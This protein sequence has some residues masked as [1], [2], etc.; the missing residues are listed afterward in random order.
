MKTG[1]L[2]LIIFLQS[3][4]ILKGEMKNPNQWESA[5]LQIKKVQVINPF[6]LSFSFHTEVK[7]LQ[8][9]EMNLGNQIFSNFNMPDESTLIFFSNLP[10]SQEIISGNLTLV[11]AD[12]LEPMKLNFTVDNRDIK[13]SEIKVLDANTLLIS[14]NHFIDPATAT[15]TSLFKIDNQSPLEIYLEENGYEVILILKNDLSSGAIYQAELG[16]FKNKEALEGLKMKYSIAYKNYLESVLVKN[17]FQILLNYYLEISKVEKALFIIEETS[18]TLKLIEQ[19][20][21]YQLILESKFPLEEGVSYNLSTSFLTSEKGLH[22]PGL[23]V[24]F[25][26]DETPPQV[27]NVFSIG[28]KEILVV[29]SEEID[30]AF[31]FNLEN[32]RIEGNTPLAVKL[33]NQKNQIAL[34]FEYEFVDKKIYELEIEQIPDLH[35]NFLEEQT[36]PFTFQLSQKNSFK[37]VVINEVMAAPRNGNVLPNAEYIELYNPNEYAVELGGFSIANSRRKT[38]FPNYSLLPKS[39]LILTLRTRVSLFTNYGEVLGLTNWPTLLNSGDQIKLF[40]ANEQLLDSLNYKTASYG[41]STFANGGYSLEIINPYFPCSES[42]NLKPS[43]DTKRGTPGMKNS[44]LDIQYGKDDLKISSWEFTSNTSLVI[45]FS[46]IIFDVG[47]IFQW[48]I[49]PNID[50]QDVF[51]EA[52]RQRIKVVFKNPITAGIKYLLN[53]G[54]I[55]DCGGNRLHDGS[56]TLSIVAPLLPLEGDVVINEVL[57]NARVG[58]PKFVEIYNTTDKYLSL[59]DW[60]LANINSSGEIANRRVLFTNEF[61]FAPYSYLVFTTDAEILKREYPKGNEANF[62]ELPSLPSYPISTGNVVLLNHDEKIKEVFNY[63]EDMHHPM[64]R[65]AR[66]V[67]LE[68]YS[69][70]FPVD[71]KDNWHSASAYIGFASPGIKN[72]VSLDERASLGIDIQP[73]IF[74]PNAQ[75]GQNFTSIRLNFST[76]GKTGSIRIFQ[77]QGQFVKEICKNEIWGTEALYTWDGTNAKGA[78]VR[79]GYYVIVFD[80][81]DSKGIVERLLKTVIIADYYLK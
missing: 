23:K 37:S 42:S 40:D 19:P 17:Q 66:G 18:D 52:S 55:K 26:W 46:K 7:F 2:I 43:Q 45:D 54:Q 13:A 41:G 81:Y 30:Q 80:Y 49:S 38:I 1:V 10:F 77:S 24:N 33:L 3:L 12:N 15:Q 70:S 57:F 47:T 59:K 51:L 22:I 25:T 27:V 62:I 61:I 31:V 9:A 64:I 58:T 5:D 73:K 35:S 39:F 74:A 4:S 28:K 48:S 53:L 14:F 8:A 34:A 76:P 79:P 50:I 68:R 32:Y 56:K 75:S 16:P 65:E 44:I 36:Y 67:S 63:H 78:L 29:F 72:S 20:N 11:I 71:K 6:I 21:P 69:P 60:K